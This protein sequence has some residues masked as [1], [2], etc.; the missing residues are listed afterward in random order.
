VTADAV[1]IT[2]RGAGSWAQINRP[3]RANACGPEVMDGLERWLEHADA[4]PEARVL[5]ITGTGR[6]FCAGA[7]M[8]VGAD[9]LH[10]PNANLAMVQRGRRLVDAIAAAPLP[11]IAAVNGFAFAGGLE[12]AMAADIVIA[13]RSATLGDR[14]VLH[15]IVPGWGSTA[16][17]P[18]LVGRRAAAALLL[19]GEDRSAE[20]FE[21]LGL[22]TEVV[23]D[24]CLEGR[25]EEV[26]ER[27]AVLDIAASQRILGLVRASLDRPLADALDAEWA[28]TSAHLASPAFAAHLEKF[29]RR[30]R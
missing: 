15:G 4:D 8:R 13:A 2:R 19:T 11:V 24:D 9:L 12:L 6:A 20:E 1:V 7:D 10:D 21:R 22:I 14:H 30:D 17:L 23:D 16:R 25:V 26:V 28:E 18:R 5:V 27:L 3:D 29:L